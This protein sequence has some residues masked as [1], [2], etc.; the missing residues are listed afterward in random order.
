[1]L[2]GN[3]LGIGVVSVCAITFASQDIVS[4]RNYRM[5]SVE[6]LVR[7]A[8]NP[9]TSGYGIMDRLCEEETFALFEAAVSYA[10]RVGHCNKQITHVNLAP[11]DLPRFLER[12]HSSLDDLTVEIT[13]G[14]IDP[15]MLA[16]VIE[17][18]HGCKGKVALDDLL[19]PSWESDGL[20]D[21]EWDLI[22]IDAS[23][24]GYP[25]ERRASV[26]ASLSQW[27]RCVEGIETRPQVEESLGLG[28]ELGQ[29]FFLDRPSVRGPR[30][31]FNIAP[32]LPSWTRREEP[33]LAMA[34][35]VVG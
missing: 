19:S 6:L 33:G 34:I 14:E 35:P 16:S 12:W 25:P 24:W 20:L 11:S 15:G 7:H 2:V 10:R 26:V 28:I 5:E 17:R 1:M 30:M 3:E 27:N 13:E 22:K 29:G 21:Q 32:P 31:T 18:I 9:S 4:L 23:F 8:M